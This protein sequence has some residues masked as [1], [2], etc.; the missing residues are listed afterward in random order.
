MRLP[1]KVELLGGVAAGDVVV[2]AGQSRLL[3]GDAL[4]VRVVDLGN[5]TASGKT[6][7]GP[8]AG[9]RT[10]GGPTRP[11]AASAPASAA[12]KPVRS[13]TLP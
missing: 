10:E 6:A 8:T 1:G 7:G 13:S 9:A 3:R 2:T 4:P 12:D 11:A 5:P